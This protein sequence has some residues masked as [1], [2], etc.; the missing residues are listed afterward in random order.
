[1][2]K[3][4]TFGLYALC[5]LLLISACGGAE[6]QETAT[7]TITPTAFPT[8]A[9]NPPTEAPEVA[10]VAAA[11]A[12]AETETAGEE[13][14][15]LDPEMVE[16][17]RDRY[18]ALECGTCHGDQGEGTDAGSALISY[19]ASQDEFIDFLRTGGDMGNDHRYPAERLSP[20]GIENLYQYLRSLSSE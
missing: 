14:I 13:G 7:P 12:M 15:T 10:T 17:G 6:P 1:M 19:E 18:V 2:I 5:V 20:N 11:T 9:F 3:R 4:W 8:F 16:R